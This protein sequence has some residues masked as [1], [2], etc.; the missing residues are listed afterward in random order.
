MIVSTELFDAYL[1]CPVKCWLRSRA[2]PTDG[3]IYADWARVQ[4]ATYCD[5]GL[6]RLL[7]T[8]PESNRAIGLP[9]EKNPIAASWRLAVDV[10]LRTNNL[11]SR[12]RAVERMPPDGRGSPGQFIPY[13]FQFAN[14]VVKNDKLMLAFDA[15]QLS[16]AV[17]REVSVGK[18][19]HGDSYATVKVRLSSLTAEVR[20]RMTEVTALL[21]DNSPPDLL[22]N[23]H[24]GQCE[25]QAR[26]RKQALEKDELSLL[27][28]IS[29]K[30][31]K[32][33]HGKGIFTV[34]QLSYT[35][36][37]RRQHRK[38]QRKQEKYH[39]SLR[40][41]AIR[42]NK[43]HAVDLLA[44]KLDGTPVYLDVE[45]LPD[46]AVQHSFWADNEEE[47]KLIWHEFLD[48]LSR[49]P[50]PRLIHFG[51]Y[52][53]V[54][55][56]RMRQRHGEPPQG[57]AANNAI[58]HAVNLLSLIFAQ[59]YF[60]TYSNGLK[61]IAGYLGFRWS[62]SPACGAEAIVWRQRWEASKDPSL[63]NALLYYNR[64][65]CEALGVVVNALVDLAREAPA[66]GKSSRSD[67]VHTADMKRENPFKFG[68]IEFALPEMASINKA[69][70][71]DYQ[72][73]RIY[74]KSANK[75][76]LR[77][78]PTLTP[79]HKPKSNV[80]IDCPA[81]PCCPTCKSKRLYGHDWKH[82][83]I[84]DLRFIKHGVKRWITRYIIHR[85]R[86]Q[87]CGN[88]F[89]PSG[90]WTPAKYG[91]NLIAYT[92]Y[93]NIELGLPLF[94]IDSS[95]SRLFG[96]RLPRGWSNKMKTTAADSYRCTYD[97]ILKR[98]CSGCL[99]HVDETSVSVRG[100]SCYVWVLASLKEVGYLYTPTREGEMIQDLLK[101]FSGVLVSDFF[102]AYDAIKC[103]QQKC[104]IHFIR[105]LTEAILNHPYDIELK[106]LAGDF[107]GLLKPMVD[108]VDRRGLTKRFLGKHRISVDR[109]YKQLAHEPNS[110]E[111][112]A[113]IIDRL[114]KN[115]NKLFTFLEFDNVPWN[116]NNAEHAVKAFAMLRRV[117]DGPTT[118]R[119]LGDFLILLSI[120]E[121]CKYKDVDFLD[122][123]RSG[124]KDIDEFA[125]SQHRRRRFPPH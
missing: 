104:L 12:L 44:P 52:E 15:L 93:Q 20:K 22:L 94:R 66:D 95:M 41:L 101:D 113:K 33:L 30:E 8:V 63:K 27:S 85:Y 19:M 3:N 70:Y 34:I 28:G 55:L 9:S 124:S 77:R 21:A 11:E 120:R 40:A 39:H 58:E 84:I 122:F 18:I 87:S 125:D 79:R 106:R 103:P 64:E 78:P 10:R 75:P 25:F 89:N 26:C 37:P 88:T 47:E 73:E 109:F 23:R 96:L 62:G 45:G 116:N 1:E 65:D 2:A 117:I 119:G 80:T 60:P 98:L 36:R 56:K 5:G 4:N 92:I 43:I 67:V 86:C 111:P 82:K 53:T 118:E 31:R 72:R 69:A 99:L 7:A 107:A 29:E 114:Q 35:F 102:A 110:S 14:K 108:T 83:T 105:D 16:A 24:C 76:L 57:L 48:V 74:V 32:K 97:T 112:T 91:H 54:F 121:T 100:A 42:E 50:D 71:W 90:R 81:P 6:K 68:R 13:R 49:V 46:R 59:I 51:S 17:G 115:R 38:V 61:E 123:M